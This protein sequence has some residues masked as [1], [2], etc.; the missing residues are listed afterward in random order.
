MVDKRY[1]VPSRLIGHRLRVRL[2]AT[3][4]EVEYQGQP[5]GRYPRLCGQGAYHIDYRHLIH[6]LLRKSGAFRRYRYREALFPT[7]TFRRGYDALCERSTRWADLEYVRL[8]HLAATTMESQVEAAI[9]VLLGAGE[10]PEY[11]RVKAEG[12]PTPNIPAPQVYMEPPGSP[13]TMR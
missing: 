6:W 1:S 2:Y 13:S 3:E 4:L 5:I 10:V 11:E 9:A 8:L 7:L 12:A